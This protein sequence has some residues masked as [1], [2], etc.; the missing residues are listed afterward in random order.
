MSRNGPVD[1]KS[2][3]LALSSVKFSFP[4]EHTCLLDN[5]DATMSV[6]APGRRRARDRCAASASNKHDFPLLQGKYVGGWPSWPSS[7]LLL[8]VS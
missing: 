5:F 4:F 8:F 2:F 7:L 6:S 3:H 1:M